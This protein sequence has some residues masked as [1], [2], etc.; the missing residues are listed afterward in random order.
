MSTLS[1]NPQDGIATILQAVAKRGITGDYR[2]LGSIYTQVKDHLILFNY[3]PAAQYERRWNA[4]ERVCRG[5]IIDAD[6]CQIVAR[7][8][9]KFFN[10]NEVE[11][12]KEE[13]LPNLPYEV[14]DKEDGS[15]GILYRHNGQYQIATRGSFTSPQAQW[16]TAHLQKHHDLTG[17]NDDLTLLF[18]IVYPENRIVL[19]Y[20]GWAGLILIGVRCMSNDMYFDHAQLVS[21]GRRYGFSVVDCARN[22]DLALCLLCRTTLTEQEGWVLRYANGLH[23]KIKTEDYL[24]L[25]RLVTGLNPK[26]VHEAMLLDQDQYL[27]FIAALPDEFQTQVEGWADM[28]SAAVLKEQRAIMHAYALTQNAVGQKADRGTFAR[29][30]IAT[31]PEYKSY[32]FALLDSRNITK[33]ILANVN[34]EVVCSEQR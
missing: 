27:A 18:E 26:R 20:E 12:A 5:L 11:E 21:M 30:V 2:D 15:L 31:Y 28:I 19:D 1:Y 9:D 6:T 25:H 3:S 33:M 24:R 13:N 22:L 34:P 10:L 4:V 17:L 7:P 32:L 29:Y 14:L 8:F 23:V 16:A